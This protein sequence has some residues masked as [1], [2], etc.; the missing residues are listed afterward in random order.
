MAI[1]TNNKTAAD[2]LC[3]VYDTVNQ[4]L[5]VVGT[6]LGLASDGEHDS[7]VGTTANMSGLEAKDF[8]GS[9]LPNAVA[10]GDVVRQAGTLSGAAMAFL[11][12]EDGSKSPVNA[13]GYLD[14]EI[15]A[16]NAG[17]ALESGGNLDTIASPVATDDSALGATPSIH[18]IGGEYRSTDSAYTDGDAT[19]F[20]TDAAGKIKIAGYDTSSDLNKIQ[21]QSP[22]HQRYTDKEN[23]VTASDIGTVDDT[24][25]D[26]GAEID[27]TGYTKLGIWCNLTVNDS[28]GN[29]LQVLSKHTA[30]GSDEYI[31]ESSSSYQKTL[32][33]SN[34]KIVY[35]FETD[36]DIPYVQIQTKATDV[37][38]GGGTEGTI[39]IDITKGWN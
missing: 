17:L 2:I 35:I 38:T 4:A 18:L 27:C 37:D 32:G 14:I 33:D 31:L 12:N 22:L 5:N 25:V 3:L 7:P 39:T 1:G 26:Q 11:T 24:W 16:D 21:E 13:S 19:I 15:Q 9:A 8:D 34:V 36:A 29:Q 10:E 23:R 28:T 30:A 20:Q 6:A